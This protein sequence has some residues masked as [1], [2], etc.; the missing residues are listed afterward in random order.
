LCHNK[1]PIFYVILFSYYCASQEMVTNPP[2]ATTI[3]YDDCGETTTEFEE[4][5]FAANP[6]PPGLEFPGAPGFA[7]AITFPGLDAPPDCPAAP[8]P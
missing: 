2:G 7:F 4:L 3:G 1:S 5:V 6:D 8:A